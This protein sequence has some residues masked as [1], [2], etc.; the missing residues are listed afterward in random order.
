ML[1]EGLCKQNQLQSISVELLRNEYD[2]DPDSD[3]DSDDEP[4]CYEEHPCEEEEKRVRLFK[5]DWTSVYKLLEC[6]MRNNLR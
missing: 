4:E 5:P 1:L 2:P 3:I 6:G